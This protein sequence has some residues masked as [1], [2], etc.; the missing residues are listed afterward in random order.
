MYGLSIAARK[1]PVRRE[2]LRDRAGRG[3][4]E[5]HERRQRLQAQLRHVLRRTRGGGAGRDGARHRPLAGSGLVQKALRDTCTD[6]G[7]PGLVWQKPAPEPQP[8]PQPVAFKDVAKDAYF[9]APA[10]WAY[11]NGV[12]SGTGKD[13]FS[14]DEGCTRAQAVTFLYKANQLEK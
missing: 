5:H 11:A 12:T 4:R 6:L 2:R 9:A 3:R 7:E 8:E 13:T 14:P 10:A 1:L